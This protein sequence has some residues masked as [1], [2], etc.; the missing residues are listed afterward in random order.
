M[1]GQGLRRWKA[2]WAIGV[3]VGV[4]AL[5][6]A[7]V[8]GTASP[9]AQAAKRSTLRV[10]AT[11]RLHLVEKDGSILRERGTVTGTPAG[12]VSAR[13]NVSKITK[14]TGTITFKPYGG[15][16]ITVT[17]AVYPA[18]SVSRFSGNFA[19]R[20]GTGKYADAVGS[21]TLSGTVNRRTWAVTATAK[22]TLTY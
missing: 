11:A 10:N 18:G 17:A 8:A 14:T 13:F 19:V 3:L 20:R 4:L 7:P 6:Q 12:S 5:L 21:G 9:A 1:I 2:A 15:G 16:S 22:G